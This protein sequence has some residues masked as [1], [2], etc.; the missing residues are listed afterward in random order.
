MLQVRQNFSKALKEDLNTSA[1]FAAL[2]EIRALCLEGL[3]PS[4][5][6][7]AL[8]LLEEADSVLG[9]LGPVAQ[10]ALSDQDVDDLLAQRRAARDSR[11]FAQ[12]DAIRDQLQ[13][14]GIVL[15]DGADGTAWHRGC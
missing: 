13:G 12:A 2:F 8:V 9:F 5:A 1:A 7:A 11:D 4:E 14:A 6:A 10:C 15:E 3:S